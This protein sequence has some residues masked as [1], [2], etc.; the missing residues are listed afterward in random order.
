M[1]HR[2]QKQVLGQSH[3]ACPLDPSTN[4]GRA[5]QRLDRFDR[6]TGLERCAQR[7]KLALEVEGGIC[8]DLFDRFV[9]AARSRDISFVPLSALLPTEPI[10]PGFM[11]RGT[12]EG[13]EGWLSCQVEVPR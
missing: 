5:A 2:E 7:S 10:E 12:I 1:C 13:R 6:M 3:R 4:G 11:T 9:T 8:R